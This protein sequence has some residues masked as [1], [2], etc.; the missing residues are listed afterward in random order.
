MALVRAELRRIG[1]YAGG[2]FDWSAAEMKLAAAKY[3]RY[4]NLGSPPSAPT[5]ALLEDLKRR[6]AGFCPPQCTAREVVVGSRCVAK[7]CGPDEVLNDAGVC[8]A[9]PKPRV[10]VNRA[11]PS[12]AA[13]ARRAPAARCLFFNGTHYCE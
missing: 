7:T 4:A 10:A 3:A 1:C 12:L 11:S 9:K 5:T 13:P 2:D 6:G 8:A